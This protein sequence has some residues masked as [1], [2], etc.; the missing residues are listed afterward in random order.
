MHSSTVAIF[1]RVAFCSLVKRC[2][3]NRKNFLSFN[4]GAQILWTDLNYM[5]TPWP[6]SFTVSLSSFL[7]WPEVIKLFSC[8]TQLSTKFQLLIFTKYRQIKKFLALN[9][10]DVV[11]IMLINVKIPT[12]V[13]TAAKLALVAAVL[14]WPRWVPSF[15][16]VLPSW[17]FLCHLKAELFDTVDFSCIRH[18]SLNV[19]EPDIFR[20]MPPLI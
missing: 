6:V 2:E 20:L 10:S 12:I 18:N 16:S 15:W 7:I 9:L 14:G 19:C 3:T 4:W 17:N 5:P 8:P 1:T 11:F 13:A